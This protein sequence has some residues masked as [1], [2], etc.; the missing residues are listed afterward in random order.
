MSA[1]R[2][3]G[4]TKRYGDTLALDD[5]DLEVRRGRGL[6]LPRAQRRRQDD[7]DPPACWA[8]TARRAGRAEIFGIDAWARPVAAHRRLA[9]VP[10]EP[11]LWPALTG[12]ETLAFLAPPARQA[13]TS[14]TATCSS[15]ASSSTRQEGAGAVEGQPPEGPADRGVRDARGPADPRRADERPRPAD[16]DGLSRD[17][18]R[19]AAGRGQTVFLSS[20]ILSEVE[21]LCDRVGDPARRP[22]RRRRARSASCATSRRRRSRSRS[23]DRAGPARAR[24]RDRR[25]RPGPTALRF[26]VIGARRPADRRARRAPGRDR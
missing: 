22:A 19:E 2:T 4:L 11:F 10:G 12:A 24:R 9:Y 1:I 16:G 7:D 18:S 23:T 8:C 26:E 14:P 17:A 15:S 13:P 3:S 5:L 25:R 21:A 20:H 6:R